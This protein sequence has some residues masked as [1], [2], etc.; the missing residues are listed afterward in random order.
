LVP[1]LDGLRLMLHPSVRLYASDHPA[2]SVW[3]AHQKDAS[4]APLHPGP[5]HALIGREPDFTVVVAPVSADTH[6]VLA[7]L[8]DGETLGRVATLAEPTAALT[9][10]LR[11][12]LIIDTVTGDTA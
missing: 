1:G 8:S 7:A 10:L 9:L 3:Q 11:H 12:G 2:V 5:S 6:A 4:R